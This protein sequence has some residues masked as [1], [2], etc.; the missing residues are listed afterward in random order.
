MP[1]KV[2]RDKPREFRITGTGPAKVTA[3]EG[4]G[5]AKKLGTFTGRAYTGAPMKPIGWYGSIVLDL[6]GIRVPN[7]HRPA[8][9]QH[10]H[11]QIVGHTD[12]VEVSADGIDIAGV[13]S[14]QDEHVEKVTVPAKRGFQWQLSVGANPIRTEFLESGETTTVNGREIAGPMTISRETELGEIS[15]VPLGADGDTSARVSASKGRAMNT[16]A[17]LKASGKFSDEQVDAM[18]EDEAK[19]A[20]KKCMKGEDEKKTEAEEEK[21]TEADGEG[22]GEEEKK[23]EPAKAKAKAED[24]EKK[25]E[26]A[27]AARIK[28]D[29]KRTADEYRRQ[30]AIQAAAKKHGASNTSIAAAI[31]KG[32]SA[33][34]AELEFLRKARPTG[35][36]TV[37]STSTPEASEAVLECAMLQAAGCQLFEEDFYKGRYGDREGM[38]PRDANRIKAEIKAR[39]PDQVQDAAHK[40]YRG[41]VGLQEA[42][43]TIAASN[44]YRGR[45]SIDMGNL[46]EVAQYASQIRADGSSTLSV[47]NI[48]ANVMNK[49]L[50][51]GY[52]YTEQAWKEICGVRS[53]KDFKAT[54]SINL[55]GDVEFQDLGPSGE[56]KN[57]TLQ[58]Q[59]FAN[60]VSTSGRILTIP[61]TV[62]INDDLGA[63]GAVPM[64]MGRGAGLKLNKVFWTKWLDSTQTDDGGSTA[65]WAATH[66]I[67][68]QKGNSNYSSGGGS[69]LGSAGLTAATLLFD[70]QVDPKGYPLGLDAEILLYPPDLQTTALELMNSEYMVYGGGSAA[71]QPANNIWKGR[72]KPV[73]S[74]YLSNADFTGYSATAWWLLANPSLI[75]TVEVAF[76]NGAEMPTVQ[77]AGPDFQFN[78]LGMTTRA[79]F[80]IGVTMQNFRGG[81]KSVG[82]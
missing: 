29:R 8:L 32:W 4:E 39:Y 65:F 53:V 24:E 60:Q 66:T 38:K 61:R 37:Y 16:R 63:L 62:I 10:D 28:A 70:K 6:D 17:M 43:T 22:E 27:A 46:G 36:P 26:S 81:V 23:E 68:N 69:A 18:D 1:S 9:R 15:F 3:A 5:D 19:A 54:K 31:E 75:P 78:I 71:K 25:A 57:A 82:S 51:Q 30:D 2:T 45:Q 33:D 12:T 20:L 74:R 14:G 11:E 50:L 13:F 80:D 73:K 79:F 42:L 44:G 56:L 67:S 7:Q 21:K 58:D 40:L 49:F 47:A 48:I 59:A 52:M 72:F 41:R 64:M 77:A 35:G 34:K 76:L 55:F